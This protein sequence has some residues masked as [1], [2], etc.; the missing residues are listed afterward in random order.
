MNLTSVSFVIPMYNE[1]KSIKKTIEIL[2]K[3]AEKLSDNYEIIIAN[4][5]STDGSGDIIDE[6]ARN[7]SHVKPVHLLKNT[8]FGGALAKGIKSASKEVIIY[9]DSDLPIKP[10]DVDSAILLLEKGDMVNAYSTI[11][12]GD[13]LKRVIMSKVYNFLIQLLFRANIKDINSG[14]KIYKAKIFEGMEL[15][16]RSPFID[17]EIFIKAIRK[18]AIVKQ[19]PIIFRQRDE[20]RSYISRPSVVIKTFIDMISFK[21]DT[22]KK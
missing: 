6:I 21:L 3:I 1:G 18:G 12:K 17:V 10:S 16:S 5:G 19:Y 2:T 13:T 11:K 4:D 14:F 22:L 8:K 9:T 20:G 7:D 15:K